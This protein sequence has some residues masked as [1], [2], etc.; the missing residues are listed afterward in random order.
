MRDNDVSLSAN[1][2]LAV[3]SEHNCASHP[4]QQLVNIKMVNN[5]NHLN[6]V[7]ELTKTMNN[8][9]HITMQLT[10]QRSENDLKLLDD[11]IKQLC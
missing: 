3:R 4:N 7:S 1:H 2:S 6:D 5:S 10:N 11:M 9:I 8:E